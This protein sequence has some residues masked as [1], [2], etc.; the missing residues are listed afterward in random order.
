MKKYPGSDCFI[1][2]V[3]VIFKKE[4]TS[5]LWKLLQKIDKERILPYLFYEA[6][7]TVIPKL[8]KDIPKK[9]QPT[10]LIYIDVKIN[11]ISKSNSA[12]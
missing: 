3:Y 7:I 8:Y 6:Y 2:E 4:K 5:V 1:G 12:A 11:S 9:I 10:Y